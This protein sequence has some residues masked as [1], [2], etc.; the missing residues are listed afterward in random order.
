M[1][2]IALITAR[3]GSKE[4]LR[5]NI[6][7]F[8]GKP[9]I[10][11]TINAAKKA[12]CIDRII[13]STDDQEIAEIAKKYGAEVPFIRPAELAKDETP[14]I[15]PVLHF[16][17][18]V[19]GF[20][21]LML[22][23]PTSPLRN[24]FDIDKIFKFCQDNKASSAVSVSEVNKHPYWMYE[25]DSSFRLRSF[26]NDPPKN[27]RRQDLPKIYSLNGAL[28]LAKVDWLVKYRSFIGPDTIGFTMPL[29][30]SV[31]LDII[32]DWNWAEYLIKQ[33]NEK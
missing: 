11:W 5:K 32:Q 29:E 21:W 25:R 16:I 9:L 15:D 26:I 28:Y 17:D 18:Q 31:D 8:S 4:I 7:L 30:R 3:G 23:Q 1:S 13:V 20:D 22:L 14:S 24:N 27:T 6:K 2:L 33:K 10:F 12:K 19:P